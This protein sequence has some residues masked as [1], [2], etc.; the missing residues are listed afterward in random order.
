MYVLIMCSIQFPTA[1][2]QGRR[3]MRGSKIHDPAAL[4]LRGG[5]ERCEDRRSTVHDLVG[6]GR[7]S[8]GISEGSVPSRLAVSSSFV[9]RTHQA[10]G[11]CDAGASRQRL[12]VVRRMRLGRARG[13]DPAP[14]YYTRTHSRVQYMIIE[15]WLATG[16]A[17]LGRW[18]FGRGTAGFAARAK[19]ER[20]GCWRLQA[21]IGFVNH[22]R[23]QR[24]PPPLTL[25][26]G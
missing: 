12:A 3:S 10:V 4:S 16:H 8:V 14:P 6:S 20:A 25:Y 17:I 23:N 15:A 2:P 22:S 24:R 7:G 13:T 18:R 11:C 19:A 9:R 26:T 5:N 1:L 21:R